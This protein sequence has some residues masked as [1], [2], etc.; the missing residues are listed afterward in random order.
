MGRLHRLLFVSLSTTRRVFEGEHPREGH[1]HGGGI[2]G[3]RRQRPSQLLLSRRLSC[4]K[5]CPI[6]PS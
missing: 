3:T 6:S 2:E 1:T 5:P 4:A